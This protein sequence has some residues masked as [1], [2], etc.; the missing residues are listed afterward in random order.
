MEFKNFPKLSMI[1][2][3]SSS[4]LKLK[5]IEET[6]NTDLYFGG[7]NVNFG[8]LDSSCDCFFSGA[9]INN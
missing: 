3:L 9:D 5:F 8:S 6:L 2:S 7:E 4:D 1:A